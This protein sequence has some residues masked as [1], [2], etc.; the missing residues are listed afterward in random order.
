MIT[1]LYQTVTVLLAVV[2]V[3]GP[4]GTMAALIFAPAIAGPFISKA[5]SGFLGC[6]VCIVVAAFIVA[7]VVSFWIGHHEAYQKGVDDTV[8]A[9]ARGD[10]KL[11]GRAKAA[12]S[13]LLNCQ[14]QDR[15]WD[16]ST[17]ACR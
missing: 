2:A 16:Q 14:E 3:L 12:R 9:V 8:A 17:G 6:K 1:G 7:S 4:I 15:T 10:A 5:V 11:V 13:K